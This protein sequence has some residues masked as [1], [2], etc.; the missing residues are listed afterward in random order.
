MGPHA[1]YVDV[2]RLIFAGKLKAV[3]G[4]SFPLED[5]AEAHRVLE[6]N[7]VFG[8]IVLEIN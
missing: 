3:I 8:K 6:E 7:E 5:F 2:M 4:A 1:D